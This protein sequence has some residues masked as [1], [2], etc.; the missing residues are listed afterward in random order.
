MVEGGAQQQAEAQVDAGLHL[1]DIPGQAGNQ[2][3]GTQPVQVGPGQGLDV[4]E[5]G[6]P[7]PGGKADGGPGGEVLGGHGSSQAQHRHEYQQ[8]RA[9][10]DH[11]LGVQAQTFVHQPGDD[12]RHSQLKQR[13]QQLESRPEDT[14]LPVGFQRTPE[15][16]HRRLPSYF[17]L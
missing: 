2:R 10:D 11:R 16:F 14:F 8:Q 9:A 4:P 15:P 13:F 6:V 1:I 5:P 7:Q 17:H 12:Q 3:G